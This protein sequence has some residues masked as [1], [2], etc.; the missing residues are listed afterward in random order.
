MR[1]KAGRLDMT[2]SL[3]PTCRT[4]LTDRRDQ[5]RPAPRGAAEA[6]VATPH[7]RRISSPSPA[8]ASN[9]AAAGSGTGTMTMS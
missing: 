6:P 4:L 3:R 9:D 7:R 5:T 2:H 8:A 1:V